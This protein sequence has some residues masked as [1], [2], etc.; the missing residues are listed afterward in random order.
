MESSTEIR[1][2]DKKNRKRGHS[3][4]LKLNR[5]PK[6]IMSFALTFEDDVI[7]LCCVSS[8]K[9]CVS[10]SP[11][12]L[13]LINTKGDNV[14]QINDVR[15]FSDYGVHTVNKESEVIYID[16]DYNIKKLSKDMKTTTTFI[17]RSDSQW[18]PLC[19]Y[20][21]PSNGDLL[22]G[23]DSV[24]FNGNRIGSK[25]FRFKQ[26]GECTQQVPR[27]DKEPELFFRP[28][29]IAENR[30]RDVVVSDCSAVVVTDL[31]GKHRFS[32]I[33]HPPGFG[34]RPSAI[35]TDALSNIL[36]CDKRTNTVQLVDEDGKFLSYLHRNITEI[37]TPQC[38]GY[39]FNNHF[40]Y[41][42]FKKKV[43]VYTY[44]ANHD[45]LTG[46]CND[47]YLQ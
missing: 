2:R 8:D 23:N 47:L 20:S 30:N 22:V 16:K 33:G 32:Y 42:A 35:C 19:V 40:L 41:V 12:K 11:N 1:I 4:L 7:H 26:T 10:R 43:G 39:D 37:G 27:D 18:Y 13:S 44:I 21:S 15:L 5:S 3:C 34:I 14:H 9:I 6:L 38:L 31:K 24:L 36:V 46:K 25:F 29:F 17:Q 28:K 45:D